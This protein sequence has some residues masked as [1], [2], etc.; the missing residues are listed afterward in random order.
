LITSLPIEEVITRV[1]NQLDDM[2]GNKVPSELLRDQRV[3]DTE[4]WH[5]VTG[6]RNGSKPATSALVS[7]KLQNW[8]SIPNVLGGYSSPSIGETGETRD[9]LRANVNGKVFFCGEHTNRSYMTLNSAMS[10]GRWAAE[11]ICKVTGTPTSQSKL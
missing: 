8:A 9:A 5:Q 1:L 7:Y 6:E 4:P 11:D 3:V 10:T 2:F